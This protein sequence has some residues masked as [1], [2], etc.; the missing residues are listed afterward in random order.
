M[1]KTLLIAAI[2]AFVLIGIGTWAG[3]RIFAPAGA[4]ADSTDKPAMMTGAKGAPTSLHD[5]YDIVVD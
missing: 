3:V 1:R 5:D 2:A 4:L